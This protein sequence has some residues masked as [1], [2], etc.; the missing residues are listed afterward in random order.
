MLAVARSRPGHDQV[1]WIDGDAT[2]AVP[3]LVADLAIMTGHV[4]QVF[5]DDAAWMQALRAVHRV[6]APG[7]RLAFE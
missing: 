1:R 7:G 4:A 2:T 3:A 6:L 5:L